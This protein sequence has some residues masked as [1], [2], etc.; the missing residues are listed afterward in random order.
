MWGVTREIVL[1]LGNSHNIITSAFN[2]ERNKLSNVPA[3]ALALC[4]QVP[5]R[6]NE[7]N[8]I[9][10][11]F[12]YGYTTPTSTAT[13]S[14][15][16]NIDA[17]I[18]RAVLVNSIDII[19]RGRVATGSKP[20]GT[21]YAVLANDGGTVSGSDPRG[22]ARAPQV[23][24]SA[25]TTLKNSLPTGVDLVVIDN[26]QGCPGECPG[27]YLLNKND[28]LAYFGSMYKISGWST[29]TLLNGAYADNLTSTS[30]NLPTGQ[31]QTPISDLLVSATHSSGTV[32]E[33]WA[34]TSVNTARQFVRIDRFSL[35]YYRDGRSFAESIYNSVERPWRLLM[36]GD[37]MCAPYANVTPSVTTT[38]T[39]P[40]TTTTTTASVGLKAKWDFNSGTVTD[41]PSVVGPALT[42]SSGYGATSI[43]GGFL[44]NTN[45]IMR[46]NMSVNNVTRI[47]IKGY[48]PTNLSTSGGQFIFITNSFNGIVI[49]ANG[50]IADNRSGGD[51][52]L[53]TQPLVN[54]VK[55]DITL[56]LITPLN[57]SFFGAFLDAGN[58]F[59]G[60]I[61]EIELY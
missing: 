17:N 49:T 40:V 35:N 51:Q 24:G 19:N 23:T 43:S 13:S 30:G 7:N 46:Y 2:V 18:K 11:S 36:I 60:S 61:D 53:T 12:T 48:T 52:I 55:Q 15:F 34:S 25:G 57:I 5:T 41:I 28:V 14:A 58:S 27:N 38:T 50:H 59:Q 45:S 16:T 29:N 54:G 22:D 1:N 31:G 42:A 47:I 26:R 32:A 37:P 4:F 10:S 21:I 44:N 20:K 39:I 3:R 9:T 33:P 56:N 8:S 6:V